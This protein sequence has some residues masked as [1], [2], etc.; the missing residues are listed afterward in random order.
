MMTPS[1]RLGDPPPFY[2]LDEYTFQNLSCDLL[3]REPG[4]ATSD[5]YGVRGQL[6]HGIDILARRSE[7][8]LEV[9]QSKRY[10]RFGPAKIIEA[11]DKFFDHWDDVW[12]NQNVQRFILLVACAVDSRQSQEEISR[13][14]DR[15]R[16]KGIH[17]EVWSIWT[18][19]EKLRLHSDLIRRHI[20]YPE[21]WLPNLLGQAVPLISRTQQNLMEVPLQAIVGDSIVQSIFVGR[22][23]SLATLQTE[24]V[25]RRSHLVQLCGP[26]GQGKTSLALRFANLHKG[27]NFDSIIVLSL[28]ERDLQTLNPLFDF[29]ALTLPVERR[30]LLERIRAGQDSL[31]SKVRA[32]LQQAIGTH[33]TLIVLDNL[34]DALENNSFK[35]SYA[36]LASFVAIVSRLGQH[37]C[38]ILITSRRPVD[39]SSLTG[40]LSPLQSTRISLENGLSVPE[41]IALLRGLDNGNCG[42]RTADSEQLAAIVEGCDGIPLVLTSLVSILLNGRGMTLERYLREPQQLAELKATPAR[43]L[44]DSLSEAERQVVQA[45]AVYG[46]AIPLVA[47]D[48]LLNNSDDG[49]SHA[50]L[51]SD[52]EQNYVVQ[53]HEGDTPTYSLRPLDQNYFFSTIV[54]VKRLHYK[55]AYFYYLVSNAQTERRTLEDLQPRLDEFQHLIK[56]EA[57]DEACKC[58]CSFDI[59]YLQSWG[60]G[61]LILEL[62]Q[63][64]IDKVTEPFGRA[65]HLNGLAVGYI[66]IGEIHSSISFSEQALAAARELQDK[67]LEEAQLGNLG[68]A[69]HMLKQYS[70][71]L[72]YYEQAIMAARQLPNNERNIAN[73]LGGAAIAKYHLGRVSNN[74]ELLESAKPQLEEA[75]AL[76]RMFDA[77]RQIL[78][79][80]LGNLGVVLLELDMVQEAIAP[81]Q[82]ASNICI[83][84][85][86]LLNGFRHLTNLGQAYLKLPEPQYETAVNH[87]AYALELAT[88]LDDRNLMGGAYRELGQALYLEG[89]W[90]NAIASYLIAYD[91][92]SKMNPPDTDQLMEL[93]RGP[94]KPLPE[95]E[96]LVASIWEQTLNM[97]EQNNDPLLKELSRDTP[98]RLLGHLDSLT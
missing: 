86:N 55:A 85:G 37:A 94:L 28:R 95:R 22:E 57:Y 60:Q 21:F 43:A 19:R 10:Q 20:P 78:N 74:R 90:Q 67:I 77:S 73:H 81:L 2:Q 34:E 58:L 17:Y 3:A 97:M 41:G 52:L 23:D 61:K 35:P 88:K 66:L 6:Q 45:L 14:T 92:L 54:D 15:F 5:H 80:H 25:E 7:G 1:M 39:V 68:H 63:H 83:E 24:L 50:R 48:V 30:D 69:Y 11:S 33:K 13:Q 75:V 76:A 79:T 40:E 31:D 18:L 84:L 49:P 27:S 56:A 44:F 59:D 62:H 64:L 71:S 96:S 51:L 72:D 42:L 53:Y 9:G 65:R 46:K 87:L 8:G 32:V 29:L 70:T 98:Q 38:Q 36:D 89:R 26:V 16:E 82:E 4:I 12:A 47:V 91:L 93:L